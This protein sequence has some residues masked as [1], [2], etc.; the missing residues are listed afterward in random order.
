MTVSAS[1]VEERVPVW[2]ALS[3]LFLDTELHHADR[4]RIAA[5]LAASSY[6]EE[7][8]EEILRFEVT[9]V[10]QTNLLSVV[11]EW[12]GFDEAW[13]REKLTPRIDR[14]P[15]FKFGVALTIRAPWQEIIRQVSLLRSK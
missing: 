4:A 15:F 3:E 13:L 11:G 14:R 2:C 12:R 6:S 10:L 7:K 8:L 9:H 1:V 5:V